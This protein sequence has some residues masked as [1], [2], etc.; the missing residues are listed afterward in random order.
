MGS[1]E[2]KEPKEGG[3]RE[4]KGQAPVDGE[5]SGWTDGSPGSAPGLLDWEMIGRS[6]VALFPS[7]KSL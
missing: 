5:G 1:P 4:G 2:A 7:P 6:P 3:K